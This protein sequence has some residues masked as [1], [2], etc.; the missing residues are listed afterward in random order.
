MALSKLLSSYLKSYCGLDPFQTK[1][2]SSVLLATWCTPRF[3]FRIYALWRS[4][5]YNVSCDYSTAN[6]TPFRNAS[7]PRGL[8]NNT[9]NLN[10][11]RFSD[12]STTKSNFVTLFLFLIDCTFAR[13]CYALIP[14]FVRSTLSSFC[15]A[16]VICDCRAICI[17]SSI[18]ASSHPHFP[19]RT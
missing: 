3:G 4:R 1:R 10:M 18:T 9:G 5:S 16:F 19:A 11:R 6:E 2:F 17:D 13:R 12:V 15:I 7:P 8:R 14:Y